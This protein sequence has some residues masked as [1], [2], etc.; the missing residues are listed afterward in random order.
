MTAPST[1]LREILAKIA[2]GNSAGLVLAEAGFTDETFAET[3]LAA[4][5]ERE[6]ERRLIEQA[7]LPDPHDERD[8]SVDW[9]RL[10][11]RTILAARTAS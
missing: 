6:A 11:I 7:L 4:L 2:A 5:S 1:D 8:V 10:Q 3:V 9:L